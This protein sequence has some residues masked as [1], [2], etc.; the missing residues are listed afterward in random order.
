MLVGESLVTAKPEERLGKVRELA[1]GQGVSRTTVIAYRVTSR[2]GCY[3]NRLALTL[4]IASNL[5]YNDL[6]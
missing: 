6:V 4:S 2:R 5:G 3:G 1:R